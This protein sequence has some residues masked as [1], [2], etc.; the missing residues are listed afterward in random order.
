MKTAQNTH[1]ALAA[2]LTHAILNGVNVH[3]ELDALQLVEELE[4]DARMYGIEDGGEVGVSIAIGGAAAGRPVS[5][6]VKPVRIV[7]G[8]PRIPKAGTIVT[9][10][11]FRT[12]PNVRTEW[13]VPAPKEGKR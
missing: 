3:D 7:N 12:V 5:V 4:A 8:Q 1:D 6:Q 9:L 13:K 2:A 10:T 11:D